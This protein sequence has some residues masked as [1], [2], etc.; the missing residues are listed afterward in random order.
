MLQ[1][2]QVGTVIPYYARFLRRFPTLRS[3]A[4]AALPEVLAAWSGLGYYRRARHLHAAARQ[5]MERLGGAIPCEAAQLRRL[6]GV[7]RY[8]AG[9]LAS[10]AFARPEPALDGNGM[11]VLSRMLA[12]R[13]H[14]ESSP[15]RQVLERAARSLLAAGPPGEVNQALMDLGALVCTPL[16]PSCARCPAKR[17]CRARAAGLEAVLPELRRGRAPIELQAAVAVIR[18]GDAC[19]LVQRADRDLM[20]GLW[21]FPGGFL[22]AGER[23]A[24]ALARLGRDCLGVALRAGERIAELRQSIT[25]RRVRVGAYAAILSEPLPRRAGRSA[26]KRRWVRPS[27]LVRLPHGSA[28]RR[29][30][31]KLERPSSRSA[32]SPARGRRAGR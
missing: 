4:R 26:T 25:Y 14:P 16:A 10:I 11:R 23:P 20:K 18:R 21:E 22:Q 27:D 28:T 32:S 19:L 3:L 9:A 7:G 29:I 12:L 31:E 8:T 17:G 1:Q 5:V 13:G 30:F 24:E 15:N 6:P 2:T